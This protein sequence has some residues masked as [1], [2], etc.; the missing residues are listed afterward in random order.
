MATLE[1]RYR[2]VIAAFSRYFNAAWAQNGFRA[3]TSIKDKPKDFSLSH[4]QQMIYHYGDNLLKEFGRDY[5]LD[6]AEHRTFPTAMYKRV[7][8]DGFVGIMVPESD[9]G[10]GL[11][12]LEMVLL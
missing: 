1:I 4:E 7:A 2:Y 9:G 12:M 6:C 5:W 3:K 11:G 10:A 8:E